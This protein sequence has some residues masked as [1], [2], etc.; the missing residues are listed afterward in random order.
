MIGSKGAVS[1]F[2]YTL[3]FAIQLRKSKE[4]LSQVSRIIKLNVVM[5]LFGP[6]PNGTT[7]FPHVKCPTLAGDAT[8]YMTGVIRAR[9]SMTGHRK[10][11]CPW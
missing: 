7:S 11:D 9:S 8:R 10:L 3:E 2:S 4:N 6:G 1:L 5:V